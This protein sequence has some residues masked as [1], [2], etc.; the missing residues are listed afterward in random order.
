MEKTDR[1]TSYWVAVTMILFPVLI[2]V[3]VLL[4][5]VQAQLLPALEDLFYQGMTLHGL[6]MV[7]VFFVASMTVAASV[8]A[9]H[10]RPSTAVSRI[11]LF[12]TVV[13]VVMLIVAILPG[14]F[15]A[16]WYF[17][18]PLPLRGNWASWATVVFLAALAV[19]G[20]AWL[21]WCLDLLRAIA[22][23][24]R[25]PEAL[26]WHYIAGRTGPEVPPSVLIITVSLIDR[27]SVV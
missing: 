17:L 4:R 12:G 22:G 9:R 19:L 23:R 8:L 24:Y 21:L 6:G 16:G 5:G 10:V 27:K 11:A 15:G 1:M 26:G 20:V 18:Y 7:G 25:L 2:L 13:G 3:G 14:G